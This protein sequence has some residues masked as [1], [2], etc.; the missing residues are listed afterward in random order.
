ME[1]PGVTGISRARDLVLQSKL[2]RE[3]LPLGVE[4][5]DIPD[6]GDEADHGMGQ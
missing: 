4:R 2:Q 1:G 3:T 6:K 5:E